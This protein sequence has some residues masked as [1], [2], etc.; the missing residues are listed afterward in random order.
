MYLQYSTLVLLSR[1]VTG[2]F[3]RFISGDDRLRRG[4]GRALIPQV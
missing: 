2:A 3:L 4:H 1:K